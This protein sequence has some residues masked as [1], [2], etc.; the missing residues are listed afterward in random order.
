MDRLP[1]PQGISCNSLDSLLDDL[2]RETLSLVQFS[3]RSTCKKFRSDADPMPLARRCA[4]AGSLTHNRVLTYTKFWH[5]THSCSS[6]L[7]PAGQCAPSMQL[8]FLL[9]PLWISVTVMLWTVWTHLL[10]A[11]C[12]LTLTSVSIGAFPTS[13]PWTHAHGSRV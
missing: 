10:R 13:L 7:P 4:Y 5:A 12:S 8:P 11:H 6:L 1:G 2:R 9:L 3:S